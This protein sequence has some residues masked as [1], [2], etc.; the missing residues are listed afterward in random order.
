MRWSGQQLDGTGASTPALPGMASVRGFLRTVTT[1]EFAGV[2]FHEVTAKTVLNRVPAD[3]AMPFRWTVNPYRGCT[4]ACVYCYARNTHTYLDLDTGEGFDRDVVV[5]VNAG[6]ALRR[7]LSR[8]SWRGEHVA[9]GTNTDPYQRAEGRYRLMPE[10]I[11]ALVETRTEFSVLTKGTLLRRDLP[12]L[13]DAASRV[14]L[15][16]GVSL[17]VY[18]DE[19]Q[20]ALEPG[21]PSAAARLALVRAVRDA[22]LPCGVMLA[23]VLPWLTDSVPALDDALARLAAAGATGVTVLPLHLRPGAKD[24]FAQWLHRHRPDLVTR[25]A[26]LYGRGA[27]VPAAYREFLADRVAPLLRRHGL[28][29]A[30]SGAVVRGQEGEFPLGSLPVPAPVS[31]LVEQPALFEA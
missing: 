14:R 26:D 13:V 17:A 20:Q 7:D 19:L 5:K 18:D 24:W 2:R 6:E 1:P 29:P 30:G 8:P 9:L 12:L 23:P 3:S 15:G 22:D 27:Y 10:I 16:L 31:P 21:T 4:H 28:A 25:Y 11:G